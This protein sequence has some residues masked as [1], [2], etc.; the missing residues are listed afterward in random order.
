MGE[1]LLEAALI[2]TVIG[3]SFAQQNLPSKVNTDALLVRL[4]SND[5]EERAQAYE[6]LKSDSTALRRANVKAALLD[7]LDRESQRMRG[8]PRPGDDEDAV[9]SEGFAEYFSELDST[10]DSFTDWSDPHQACILVKSG[11]VPASSSSTEA[12][13]RERVA[14]QCLKEMSVSN[15]MLDRVN[16][17]RIIIELSARAG[18]ALDPNT[19]QETRLLLYKPFIIRMKVFA[20][21]RWSPLKDLEQ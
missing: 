14:W 4:R 11:D 6:Q 16:A 1:V 3:A 15:V 18:D 7:L 10:V 17:S 20:A 9:G 21:R 12:A 5:G 19:V 8:V 13:T 2:F